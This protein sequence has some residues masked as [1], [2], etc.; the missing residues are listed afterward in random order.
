[1]TVN[2]S[3]RN[4]VI[5]GGGDVFRVKVFRGGDQDT[6]VLDIDSVAATPNGSVCSAANPSNVRLDQEDLRFDLG[7]YEVEVTIVDD[8]DDDAIKHAEMGVFSLS[9]TPEGDI[10]LS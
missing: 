5:F 1:V 6:P 4:P 7:I 2:G 9:G 8:S 10:G 3:D